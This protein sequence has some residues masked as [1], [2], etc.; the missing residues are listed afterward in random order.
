MFYNICKQC[1]YIYVCSYVHAA[2]YA[3]HPVAADQAGPND[4]PT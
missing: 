2:Y 1:I 4:R 3:H